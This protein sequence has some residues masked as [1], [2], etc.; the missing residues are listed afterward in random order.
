VAI[1]SEEGRMISESE[2]GGFEYG[3]RREVSPYDHNKSEQIDMIM[4][5]DQLY[6]SNVKP[7][8]H[9][10]IPKTSLTH[11]RRLL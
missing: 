2:T 4:S 5:D 7:E 8:S 3:S 10:P 9:M 11:S 1:Q 6:Y